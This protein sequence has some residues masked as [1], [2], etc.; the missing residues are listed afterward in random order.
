MVN[1]NQI[2]LQKTGQMEDNNPWDNTRIQGFIDNGSYIVSKSYATPWGSFEAVPE[3][4]K[5]AVVIFSAIEF[6]WA[7]AA[8]H[9]N[10]YDMQV[11]GNAYSSYSS[12][13]QRSNVLFDK[14]VKMI[15]LL[16][17]E[18]AS[19]GLVEEGSGDIIIGD[20]VIRS[21]DTGYLVPRANDPAGDWTN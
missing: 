18:L 9:A 19:L 3:K 17:E 5:Y 1:Y 8:D 20:L 16:K 11:G 14:A 4:Y 7:K 2:F 6:W 21:F 15:Q 13:N 10:S 12:V